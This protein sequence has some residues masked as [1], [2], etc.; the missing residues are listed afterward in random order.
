[1]I[2]VY[3]EDRC[4]EWIK[5]KCNEVT[6]TKCLVTFNMVI[7]ESIIKYDGAEAKQFF[8]IRDKEIPIEKVESVI[9]EILI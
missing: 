1:M 7:Y 6:E 2:Q 9:D 3:S 4:P 5:R 8:T